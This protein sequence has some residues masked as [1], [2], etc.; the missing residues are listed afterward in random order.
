MK[1]LPSNKIV[2]RISVVCFFKKKSMKINHDTNIAT[3]TAAVAQVCKRLSDRAFYSDDFA[4]IPM[5]AFAD[6]LQTR[7]MGDGIMVG[8]VCGGTI[9]AVINDSR[10]ELRRNNLFLLRDDSTVE[11]F[12][13]SKA[14]SGYVITLSRRFLESIDVSVRDFIAARV[15][16]HIAPCVTST[17]YDTLRLHNITLAIADAVDGSR[18]M[19]DEKIM[20][21]LFSAFFYTVASILSVYQ[22]DVADVPRKS[23]SEELMRQFMG[24]LDQGCYEQRSVEFYAAQMGISPKYLSLVCNTQTGQSASKVID[25]VVIRKAKELL[26]QSGVS[27]NEVAER[28]GFLSQSF[29][30]KYFK[31][32]VGMSPSRY[33]AQY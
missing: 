18:Y 28:M 30:G 3:K 7:G 29:F 5:A 11:N 13:C 12:K 15:M 24:L 33:K 32:R 21:A 26:K 8:V 2:A 14:C 4:I 27:V 19:Y 6:A 17:A 25:E 31:Q 16:F 23:R 20:S 22:H 10:Y 9:R 1:R